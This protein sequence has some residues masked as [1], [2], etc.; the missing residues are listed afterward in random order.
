MRG[1]GS[2]RTFLGVGAVG[3]VCGS[4][5]AVALGGGDAPRAEVTS[6]HADGPADLVVEPRKAPTE[7]PEADAAEAAARQQALAVAVLLPV[8]ESA[9]Q[10]L[11][12]PGEAEA[13][14]AA[15]KDALAARFGKDAVRRGLLK[16]LYGTVGVGRFVRGGRLTALGR[17]VVGRVGELG[18]HG[19]DPGPYDVGGLDAVVAAL[20]GA[21]DVAEEPGDAP[22]QD[23]TTLLLLELLDGSSFDATRAAARLATLASVPTA[24]EVDALAATLQRRGVGGVVR[25]QDVTPD[26]RVADALV[27]LVLDFRFVKKAGPFDLRRAETV[28][29][30]RKEGAA[31]LATLEKVVEGDPATATE[32]LDPPH[33]LYAGML[34][35]HD[36]YRGYVAAG[37][38]KELPTSWK[39][40]PGAKGDEVKR[41]Q[42]RLACEGYYDGPL[43][44]VYEGAALAAG[45]AYQREHDL[46]AEGNIFEDTLKSM[47]VS[48][49]R[50]ADQIALALQRMRES[51]IGTMA[52]F[53]IRVNLP[54]FELQVFESGKVIRRQRVIVG[55]NRLDDDKQKL[56][57]GHLNRTDLFTTR[58]YE[59]IVHPAWILPA[60]VEHG[61]LQG[62][63]ADDPEY[64]AKHNIKQH[65][66]DG[67]K[68]VYI[69]GFGDGNVLGEVKFLLEKSNAIYL[70]DT[71]KPALFKE[72]RRDFS[73]GCM[74]VEGAVDFA[75]WILARDGFSDDE[76][77]RSFRM[78]D[79]Q[80]G[81]DLKQPI[82]LI[83]EYMTVDL[84]DDGRPVF[85]SDIYRYDRDYFDGDL[86][87]QVTTRW[88]ATELRPR[89]V[90]RVPQETVDAWRAAG[91]PAP[92]N[93]DPA[94]DAP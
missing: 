86:P 30:K 38:C 65:T 32:R 34:A 61:E 60:R 10:R 66:L 56:V 91:K 44:G 24:A 88:G 74:R 6:P 15:L 57:Q 73:H 83:T 81:F 42:T 36:R 70:H 7:A 39:I 71:D 11:H 33:P 58:L 2:N 5:L 53:F 47:N 14:D 52:D 8:I 55:T 12:A 75:K 19:V 27:Q 26:V 45:R 64:L 72:R 18:R 62:K 31:L 69:Q 80:R 94:K 87:P 59:V 35:V 82:D 16:K 20:G 84:N 48:M 40:R 22:A 25:P 93:Y 23:D 21:A 4:L 41:L 78:T 68:K 54:A 49:E 9:H 77:R 85:L 13:L 1:L 37:G 79:Y 28:I 92:R 51:D 50:R 63:L 3:L 29:E 76:V 43:D 67:G 89:W 17:A 46:P 90:P